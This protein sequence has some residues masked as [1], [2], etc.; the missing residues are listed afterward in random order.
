VNSTVAT[1][2]DSETLTCSL[3]YSPTEQR[4]IEIGVTISDG[5]LS[6]RAMGTVRSLFYNPPEVDSIDTTFGDINGGT[7]VIVYGSYL[8]PSFGGIACKFGTVVVNAIAIEMNSL[9]KCI[10]PPALIS[11]VSNKVDF[12]VSVD[13]YNYFPTAS[14]L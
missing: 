7:E 8:D 13:G 4:H 14:Q 5:D 2:I 1:R 9:I 12:A 6:A 11:T 10:S 3:P